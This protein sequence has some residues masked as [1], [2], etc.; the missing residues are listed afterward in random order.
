MSNALTTGEVFGTRLRELRQKR[1]WTQRELAQSADVPQARISEW[2]SGVRT[3]NLVTI[4]RLA[5]ALNCKI[6]EL[7]SGFDKTDLA[8]LKL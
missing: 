7:V 2:E 5:I 8:L 3:P 1:K 6:T 4:V